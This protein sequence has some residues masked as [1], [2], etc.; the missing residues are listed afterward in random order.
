M[1]QIHTASCATRDSD[2]SDLTQMQQPRQMHRFP[3]IGLYPIIRRALQLQ[4]VCKAPVA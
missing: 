1:H 3:G 4:I 2:G